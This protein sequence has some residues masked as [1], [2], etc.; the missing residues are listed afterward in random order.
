[1]L[2]NGAFIPVINS[3]GT[4][5]QI[6]K[7]I[8]PA[9]KFQ[10]LGCYAQTELGHGSNLSKLETTATFIKETDEWE[11]NSTTF[12]ASKWWIG[13]LG[14]LSTHA[15]VQAR[16]FIDG[17]DYGAHVF[18]IPLRSLDDHKT[19]PGVEIGDIGPK[20]YNGFNK[21]DNGCKE[22]C[23]PSKR[24]HNKTPQSPTKHSPFT[25]RTR[26]KKH[27]CALQQVPHPS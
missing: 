5:E 2:H 12:T 9:E 11:I 24:L 6:E 23:T 25:H 10:I 13:G 20:A 1:M 22:L 15:V 3:Q 19:F 7:W 17:K 18:V 27:S 16:L 26:G 14:A 4:D 21:M 8:P